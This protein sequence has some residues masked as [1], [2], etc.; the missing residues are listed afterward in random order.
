VRSSFQVCAAILG[1]VLATATASLGSNAQPPP[2]KA[3]APSAT[4]MACCKTCT[5]GKACGNSCIA[6]YKDCHQ[7]PG[8][9]CDG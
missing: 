9:A 6:K 8:C 7:P 2:S 4:P 3:R 1:L 5:Q